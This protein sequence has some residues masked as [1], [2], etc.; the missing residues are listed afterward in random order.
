MQLVSKLIPRPKKKQDESLSSLVSLLQSSHTTNKPPIPDRTWNKAVMR[1]I[2]AIANQQERA[3]NAEEEEFDGS[4]F[5]RFSFASILLA[6]II[7]TTT[8]EPEQILLS[9]S[10]PMS[11]VEAL[12]ELDPFDI[13]MVLHD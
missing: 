4:L 1:D 3:S 8:S 7:H 12:L 10:E 9:T 2:H 6:L 5:M 13:S 11:T